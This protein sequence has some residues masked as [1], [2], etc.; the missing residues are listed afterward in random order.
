M[1]DQLEQ[2][3]SLVRHL[4]ALARSGSLAPYLADH[5]Q[6]PQAW[7]LT[8]NVDV[9]RGCNLRCLMCASDHGATPELADEAI[10]PALA[11]AVPLTAE[12]SVGCLHEPTLHPEL[13]ER[14]A[15]LSAAARA[16]GWTGFLG[17]LTSGTLLTRALT[18]RLLQAG[19]GLLLSIDTTDEAAYARV[20]RPASWSALRPQVEYLARQAEARGRFIAARSMIMA[21]TLPHLVA[22]IEELAQ[23]GLRR[24]S[25]AQVQVAPDASVVVHRGEHAGRIDGAVARL[26]A[27]ARSTELELDLPSA[28]DDLP[29]GALAPLLGDGDVWDEHR[30]GP[31]RRGICLVPWCKV[32]VDHAGWVYPCPHKQRRELAWGNLLQQPL[33]RIVN[34]ASARR[35]R[36]LL[37]AG[38]A[39]DDACRR[40]P[41]G[42]GVEAP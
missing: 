40:C 36:E 26:R 27:L 22:T 24:F 10:W 41:Y 13:P 37:L 38:Q 3:R 23:M 14:L 20:R 33:G 16:A 2:P 32:R 5:V 21:E 30:V 28:P 39:P 31:G 6:L 19:V 1:A 29:D 17:L 35:D 15:D 12:L 7:P 34:G 42:P 9:T 25:L 4:R 11:E 8:V 18:D